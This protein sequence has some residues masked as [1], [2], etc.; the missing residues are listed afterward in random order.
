MNYADYFN[1]EN[2]ETNDYP[3]DFLEELFE[4]NIRTLHTKIHLLNWDEK[5]LKSIEGI[6]KSGNYSVDGSS[7]VRR[8]LSMSFAT[9][10]REDNDIKN[11]LSPDKKINL[12]LGLENPTDRFKNDKIIWFNMGI[13]VITAPSFNHTPFG[14]EI[15]IEAQDKMS[16]MNGTLGGELQMP[17]QFVDY[18]NNKVQSFS[19]R[20][21]FMSS[22]VNLGNENPARV[23][24][25]SVPDYINEYTQVKSIKGLKEPFIHKDAPEGV[26]GER[27]IVEAWHP[28]KSET[29]MSFKSGDRV[30]KLRRFGPP[31]PVV[32]VTSSTETYQKNVGETV[33]SIFED[34][35]EALSNTHEFFYNREGDLLFQP[36]QSFVNQV[37]DATKDSKLGYF[38]YELNMDDFIPDYSGLPFTYNLADK[39]TIIKY[40]NNPSYD[41]IKNDF[42]AIGKE[43]QIMQIAIDEK[44]TTKSIIDW[45]EKIG[46]QFHS[47][48]PEMKFLQKDGRKRDPYNPETRAV[49]YETSEG[50]GAN[51]PVYTLVNLDKVPWQIAHGIKNYYIRNIYGAST[52]RVLPRWGMECE[53]MIFKRT[54]SYDNKYLVP[55]MG[56]FNLANVSSGT[57]WLAGYPIASSA[58]TENDIEELDRNNP[59]FTEEGDSS[60]WSYYIDLISDDSSLGKFSIASIGKRTKTIDAEA[61]TTMFKIHP[62]E[63]VIMTV[64]DLNSYGGVSI[65]KDLRKRSQPYIV[66]ENIQLQ[67]FVPSV[68]NDKEKNIVKPYSSIVYDEKNIEEI[69]YHVSD[70]EKTKNYIVGGRYTGT[71]KINED[72]KGNNFLGMVTITKGDYTHPKTRSVNSLASNVEPYEIVTP[73]FF[74]GDKDKTKFAFLMYVDKSK[75]NLT[76]SGN[77]PFLVVA[78][79]K[80]GDASKFQYAQETEENGLRRAKW[81]DFTPPADSAILFSLERD[82]Y[83][84]KEDNGSI[85]TEY[86]PGIS[87]E[88]SLENLREARMESLFV[89]DG[90][91]D[92]FS[93]LRSLIYMHTSTADV[94]SIEMLPVY[95]L[96]PNTLIYVEDEMANIKGTFMITG[97][98]L[99]LGQST[100]TLNAIET[101]TRI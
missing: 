70:K 85:T 23:V 24:I 32:A 58:V 33:S 61:A 3:I 37:F 35:S 26:E 31:D 27:I 93:Y 48:S 75:V 95:N 101:N 20:D 88:E 73:M 49:Y 67:N 47:E 57:P 12:Y 63:V 54:A 56:I 79:P 9:K 100:M 52:P 80:E 38:R 98:N 50:A 90:A 86:R 22:A 97:Y 40:T 87:E 92:L 15:T 60:F 39:K 53:S 42:V 18:I 6:V 81:V 78:K 89:S 43:G 59:I 19:W 16:L 72:K 46:E 84:Y 99:S 14:A 41:N 74:D 64:D 62:T 96:E 30:Y 1:D 77:H 83:E 68:L 2:I 91:V 25:D 36:I 44:P 94:I 71:I 10:D 17:I 7:S 11:Y 45:F 21:I 29:D 8:N 13:F 5:I 65:L 76:K 66:I 69:N 28:E 34:I 55:N 51:S 82:Y 4:Y